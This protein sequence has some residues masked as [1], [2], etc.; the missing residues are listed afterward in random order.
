MKIALLIYFMSTACSNQFS[1]NL[2]VAKTES[3]KT[4]QSSTSAAVQ[5]L[6][7]WHATA[8]E[9]QGFNIEHSTD[10][11]NFIQIL[12]IADGIYFAKVNAI[13]GQK[14]YF[15]IRG[16]NEAGMSGYSTIVLGSL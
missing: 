12:Q 10:G 8:G 2:V 3:G 13:V 11:I 14:N 16:Y 4:P 7:S 6:L 5:M 15:R 9:Q 1:P